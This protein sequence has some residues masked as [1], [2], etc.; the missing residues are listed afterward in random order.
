MVAFDPS[1]ASNFP[2]LYTASQSLPMSPAERTQINNISGALSKHKQLIK[3]KPEDAMKEFNSMDA[4]AKAQ[5]KFLFK[6]AD[7][8]KSAPNAAENLGKLAFNALG[9]IASPLRLAF[10]AAE[11][12]NRAINV[13][14]LA[15]RQFAQGEDLFNLKTWGRAWDGKELY[16]NEAMGKVVQEYG[17]ARA[18]VAAKLLAGKTPGEIL[19]SYGTLNKDIISAV[20]EAFT[21]PDSFSEVLSSAK[22]AQ[23]SPGRDIVRYLDDRAP[24]K[25]GLLSQAAQGKWSWLSGTLDTVY[26]FAVDPI[27]WATGGTS[28]AITRADKL[29]ELAKQGKTGITEVFK[30]KGVQQLWGEVGPKI[31]TYSE[32]KGKAAKDEVLK[33]I[34]INHSGLANHSLIETLAKNE[35]FDASSA[36]K[37]FGLAEN[38]HLLTSGRV[39]GTTY[40]RSGVPVARRWREAEAKFNSLLDNTFNK[41]SRT[42]EQRE[43]LGQ[44]LENVFKSGAELNPKKK[45]WSVVDPLTKEVTGF[46]LASIGR[47]MARHPGSQRIF[48]TDDKVLETLPVFE[49]LARVILP[50]DMAGYMTQVFKDSNQQDRV[51]ILRNMY[52]AIMYEMG[53][54]GT[55][56]GEQ[57]MGNIL[58]EKFAAQ[59]GWGT[60]DKIEVAPQHLDAVDAETLSY[61]GIKGEKGGF[62]ISSDGTI[63]PFQAAEAI[64]GLPWDSIQQVLAESIVNRNQRLNFLRTIGGATQHATLK[65]LTDG[66]SFFTLY[67]RLGVRGSVDESMFYAFT[68]PGTD[69]LKYAARLGH[70]M[71]KP[72]QAFTA[73]KGS[74]GPWKAG[75]YRALR[76]GEGPASAISAAK[77]KEILSN[78]ELKGLNAREELAKHAAEM[79]HGFSKEDQKY[80]ISALMYSPDHISGMVSSLLARTGLKGAVDPEMIT[81]I[82]SSS[83]LTEALKDL[84]LKVGNVY[85]ALDPEELAKINNRFPAMAHFHDFFLRFARN[86]V[87]LQAEKGTSVFNPAVAYLKNGAGKTKENYLAAKNELLSQ[88]GIVPDKAGHGLYEIKDKVL[89]KNFLDPSTNT[90]IMRDAGMSDIQIARTQIDMILTD[91]HETFHGSP[92][93]FNQKLYDYLHQVTEDGKFV[94]YSKALNKLTLDEFEKLTLGY[95]PT[96]KIITAI[97]FPGV[98]DAE[99]WYRMGV[100]KGMEQMDRQVNGIIRQ[101]AVMLTYTRLRR[102]YEK[103]E[104]QMVE[105]GVKQG[106]SRKEAEVFADK[107]FTEIASAEAADRV[108]KFVDNPEVRSQF[109]FGMRTLGRFY[110][111][112]EDFNRRIYRMATD[113][114]IETLWRMRL[115]HL[116]L[117]ASG[118][119][120]K[121]QQGNPYVMMPM[122]NIIYKATDTTMRVL[123]APLGKGNVGYQQPIFNDFTLKLTLANPSFD[124]NA[125]QPT[126][127]GPVAAMSILSAKAILGMVGGSWGK[128]KAEE[129]DNWGLGQVGDNMTWSRALIPSTLSRIWQILDPSE[130]SRQITT[131]AQQ[132]MAYNA[133]HGRYL[134]PDATD[135]EKAEYLKN[136]RISAHNILAMRSFLGLISP[137]SP[138]TQESM[139]VPGYLKKVGMTGLTPEFRSIL[140]S[141]RKKSINE[142]IVDPYEL[143]LFTFIGKYPNRLVYTLSKTN[144]N[145]RVYVQTAKNVKNWGIANQGLIKNYGEV[146]WLFAPQVGKF[147]QASYL[148]MQASG[149]FT[150]K[151]LEDYFTNVQSAVDT[152]RYWDIGTE[153]RFQLNNTTDPGTRASIIENAKNQRAALLTA[154]PLLKEN[155][156]PKGNQSA[157]QEAMFRS[158][159]NLLNDKDANIDSGVRTKMRLATEEIQKFILFCKSNATTSFSNASDLKYQRRIQ[160]EAFLDE[161]E[162][163][164]LTMKEARKSVFNPVIHQ[165]SRDSYS[166]GIRGLR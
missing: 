101:P 32:A 139:D 106:F 49:S 147:D 143:A 13:P 42:T 141:I 127:S 156:A 125:S 10:K 52:G 84:D 69:V 130:K 65:N 154:N 114:P 19:E 22:A 160:L 14:Y 33:D 166:V 67:P 129:L 11:I 75:L 31:K 162:A 71:G 27:T 86:T 120:Y 82:F 145:Q 165:Y 25:G 132:A 126:L 135:K 68:A 163:G 76:Q 148:W 16:D 62:Y 48:I 93:A 89:L 38:V 110:R 152:Q 24:H 30:D 50:K 164:D 58:Q 131:A 12:Y 116:G 99:S 133:A 8:T 159:T 72:V 108:L 123:G 128:Q 15:L 28:K 142:D 63:H 113:A 134:A 2:T 54:H 73:S 35:V 9:T 51:L 150:Q 153:E 41:S 157:K 7:Y 140:D 87:T 44:K 94:P 77:R 117:S 151:T 56:K 70:R 78:A 107:H 46:K 97:D 20:Q 104:K 96:K 43:E 138:S 39:V 115:A 80:I 79:Y 81:Q 21:S 57:L 111:A 100:N 74:I 112:T 118:S 6:D 122:D 98:A 4:D 149:L 26:Q 23:I 158:L 47:L 136:L 155:I 105:D 18:Y 66:W 55:P 45:D 161:L 34:F 90:S 102:S 103:W 40:M 109:S 37:F 5:L 88:V 17:K 29:A 137:V 61:N 64:G 124:P 95:T 1:V 3:M 83:V 85:R 121:D 53:L 36:E 60:T 144:K 119:V 59:H 146:A 91:L 92:D